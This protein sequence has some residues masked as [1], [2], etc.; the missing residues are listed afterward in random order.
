MYRRNAIAVVATLL[1]AASSSWAEQLNA[2]FIAA[3]REASISRITYTGNARTKDSA[4]AKLSGLKPGMELIDI[5]PESIEQRLLM[6]GILSEVSLSATEEGGQV[7]ITILVKEK[8]TLMP[9]PSAS[10]SKDGW[11]A[12]LYL[13]DFNF[14]GLRR[15]LVVGGGLTDVGA[16]GLAAY[17]DPCFLGTDVTFRM[18]ASYQKARE[19]ARTMDGSEFS[20]FT[21]ESAKSMALLAY[22]FDDELSADLFVGPSYK[23]IA[24]G[25]A[26]DLDLEVGNSLIS[27][28]SDF[29]VFNGQSMQGYYKV[30]PTATVTYAHD[31]SLRG[32]RSY[33][34]LSLSATEVAPLFLDGFVSLGLRAN[35]SSR[36]FTL[37]DPLS[38]PGFRTLP[39][40]D[41]YSGTYA[42]AY[43]SADLPVVKLS[44]SVMTLGAFYEAGAYKTG[45]T[46]D[47]R[48]FFHGPGINYSLYLSKVAI[49]AL[50]VFF[51]CNLPERA[52]VVS[53]NLGL[54]F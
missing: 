36:P 3:H 1:F 32:T 50:S 26:D 41:S 28:G 7:A 14:M 9:V 21:A 2:E 22:P 19:V 11:A 31:F 45:P 5:T 48:R 54:S 30:G 25:D 34:N 8:Q 40:G 6:S 37:W 35:L 39:Q 52:P 43:A 18:I 38:G 12:G 23:I 44:W 15:M 17:S 16:S 33:D 20:S 47:E 53:A 27:A 13:L 49:P 46:A 29:I 51:A 24:G 42:S 4:L 10:F